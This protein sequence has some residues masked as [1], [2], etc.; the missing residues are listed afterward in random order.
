[1][2]VDTNIPLTQINFAPNKVEEI[3]QNVR[4]ILL[5]TK[6][7]APLNRK[8]G[9][10]ASIIDTSIL[11][12]AKII[13]EIINNINKYEPRVEVTNIEFKNGLSDST[14]VIEGILHP[15]VTIKIKRDL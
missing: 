6:Y 9:I 2:I 3:M 1:M 4:T 10:D 15:K 14:D 12:K 11:G 7:S 13:S 5:T 8:F